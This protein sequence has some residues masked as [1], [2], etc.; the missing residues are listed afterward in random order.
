MNEFV[1][2]ITKIKFS[3]TSPNIPIFIEKTFQCFINWGHQRKNTEIKLSPVNQKRVVNIFLD[4]V[5]AILISAAWAYQGSYFRHVLSN[6]NALSPIC[7]FT[8]FYDPSV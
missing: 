7:I 5:G 8:G 6:I 1:A 3:A 2:K 4:D